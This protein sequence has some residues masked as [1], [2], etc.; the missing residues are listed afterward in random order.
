[1]ALGTDHLDNTTQAV[2]EPNIWSSRVNDFFRAKLKVGNFFEDWSE[3]VAEGG[4]TIHRPSIT[5]MSANDKVI[6]SEVTLNANN[7]TKVDLSIDTH[8]ETSFVI[9]DA[10]ASKVK[11]SYRIQETY[12]ENA[13]YTTA[14]TLEDALIDLFTGFSN[15]VG[16]SSTDLN[17]SNIRQAF[18]IEFST[19]WT[20]DKIN[21]G[22]QNLWAC[23]KIVKGNYNYLNN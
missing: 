21:A 4:D 12:A 1:M 13:A 9:E 14:A 11:R 17:D 18:D 20:I 22:K 23:D 10:V 15:T 6:G 3:D 7:E 8:K 16:D 2:M 5:E 19:K